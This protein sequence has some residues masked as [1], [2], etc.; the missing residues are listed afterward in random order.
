MNWIS[1][2]QS[3]V[4]TEKLSFQRC[5]GAL[6]VEEAK[7]LLQERFLWDF[8]AMNMNSKDCTETELF[9]IQPFFNNI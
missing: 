3:H 5:T 1:Y 2:V 6:L 9:N 8:L 4:Y 7:Q